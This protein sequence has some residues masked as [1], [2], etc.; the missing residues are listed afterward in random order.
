MIDTPPSEK[1][2]ADQPMPLSRAAA[3]QEIL[4]LSENIEMIQAQ[5]AEKNHLDENGRRLNDHEYHQWRSRAVWAMQKKIGQRRRIK[6][7]LKQVC[8]E[9]VRIEAGVPA[10]TNPVELIC[11]LMAALKNAIPG[12]DLTDHERLLI[13]LAEEYIRAK[14]AAL[15]AKKAAS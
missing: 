3:E 9:S 8:M 15:L 4:D 11:S 10:P 1:I 14:S 12:P 7:W 6:A 2:V 5:L 13:R